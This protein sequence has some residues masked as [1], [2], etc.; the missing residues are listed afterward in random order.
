MRVIRTSDI[1]VASP[2]CVTSLARPAHSWKPPRPPSARSRERAS[3]T[4]DPRCLPSNKNLCPATP[5]RAPGSGVSRFRGLA[6][7]IP[8]LDAF[9]PPRALADSRGPGPRPRAPLP[10]GDTLLWTSAPLADFCNLKQ[11]AGTPNERS[12]LAREWSFRPATRRHQPMPVALAL[13]T[14]PHRGPASLDLHAPAC[15]RRV[16]LAWTGQIEGRSVRA[17]AS[18]ALLD[19]VARALLVAPRAPGSPVRLVMRSGGP[20]HSSPRP[21]FPFDASP[22]RATPSK[23]PGCLLPRRNPYASGGWLLRARLDRGLVTPPPERHCS[24]TRAPLLPALQR[25]LLTRKAL[26]PARPT[27]S[28]GAEASL[29]RPVAAPVTASTTES[30]RGQMCRELHEPFLLRI[31]VPRNTKSSET[32]LFFIHLLPTGLSTACPL[33]GGVLPVFPGLRGPTGDWGGTIAGQDR[34]ND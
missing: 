11:R 2:T 7:A 5:S 22:R 25:L 1:P 27:V 23:E 31:D 33:V 20:R 17:K 4:N 28:R 3:W 26:E 14:L 34:T 12:I 19:D 32:M 18:R 6:T 16:P 21:R 15:A 8:V 24:E 29:E 9:S 13:D 10:T 30:A